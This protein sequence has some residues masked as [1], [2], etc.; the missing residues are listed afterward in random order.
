MTAKSLI[1]AARFLLLAVVASGLR[2]AEPDSKLRVE[3][4]D[5][6]PH[7]D[8]H[9]NRLGE[10]N[11]LTVRQDFG[12]AAESPFHAPAIGGLVTAAAAP[13]YYARKLAARTLSDALSVSGRI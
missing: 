6:D 2:A 10:N 7:W 9:N 13:A 8:G 4:F 5:Q 11:P 1:N 3:H 12:Y